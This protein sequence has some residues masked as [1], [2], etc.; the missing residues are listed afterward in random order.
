MPLLPPVTRT[1]VLGADMMGGSTS[2]VSKE[3]IEIVRLTKEGDT[4]T[5]VSIKKQGPLYNHSDILD[6]S[7]ART[8]VK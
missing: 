6:K 5:E 1:V 8:S 2:A 3:G 4:N 7:V